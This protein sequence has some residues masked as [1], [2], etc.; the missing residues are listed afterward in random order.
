ME[1]VEKT[2]LETEEIEDGGTL[3]RKKL[4]EKQE[5]NSE[6]EEENDDSA[7]H[8]ETEKPAQDGEEDCS[9]HAVPEE[10]K[11]MTNIDG[12]ELSEGAPG[13]EDNSDPVLNM[14]VSVIE[15]DN[16]SE[17]LTETDNLSMVVNI[18]SSRRA[19]DVSNVSFPNFQL[20]DAGNAEGEDPD[21]D[22]DVD[23]ETPYQQ[24][25]DDYQPE[26]YDVDCDMPLELGP[27]TAGCLSMHESKL[28]YTDQIKERIDKRKHK[29]N[30]SEE[31][32][33]DSNKIKS[34]DVLPGNKKME[35]F[36][37]PL[38]GVHFHDRLHDNE[39]KIDG[40]S[41][42]DLADL[43]VK[44][45][46]PGH[47][48]KT[49]HSEAD[50]GSDFSAAAAVNANYNG[51][52][53]RNS[54]EVRNNIPDVSEVKSYDI[55]TVTDMKSVS[56]NV[57]PRMKKKSPGLARRIADKEIL[58]RDTSSSERETDL[59]V[60]LR[61]H[62][63]IKSNL[64][65]KT[66]GAEKHVEIETYDNVHSTNGAIHG[67]EGIKYLD[68]KDSKDPTNDIANEYDYVKFMRVQPG[69]S[70]V[71][72]RLAYSTSDKPNGSSRDSLTNI[73][74]DITPESQ[75]TPKRTP[76]QSHGNGTSFNPKLL[77]ENLTEIPLNS[78]SSQTE[79]K[80][81]SLSP[82]NT[83]C[84]SAEVESICS[85]SGLATNL[86][87]SVEDGLSSS[88]PSDSDDG[89]ADKDI[90]NPIDI[91]QSKQR[92]EAEQ[93]LK[94]TSTHGVSDSPQHPLPTV[95]SRS[96]ARSVAQLD[97]SSYTLDPL[98]MKQYE[99]DKPNDV[100]Q[101]L[102]DITVAIKKS[103]SMPLKAPYH[104]TNGGE[105]SESQEEPVWVMRDSYTK[106]VQRQEQMQKM[107]QEMEHLQE[108][109]LRSREEEKVFKLE[110]EED[111]LLQDKYSHG[112]EPKGYCS[113]DEY[114][115]HDR[116]IAKSFFQRKKKYASVPVED[117]SDT[118]YVRPDSYVKSSYSGGNVGNSHSL[119]SHGSLR[120]QKALGES[121][122]SRPQ[123][124][125][126]SPQSRKVSGRRIADHKRNS[127]SCDEESEGSQD[128]LE[129]AGPRGGAYTKH[130][131]RDTDTDEE[132]DQLLD[133][134]YTKDTHVDI[135]ELNDAP[136]TR[137]ANKLR[138]KEGE[139]ESLTVYDPD[140]PTV[141]IEGVLFRALYLGSTQLISEGTPSKAMRMMQ[142][143]EAVGRIKAPAGE[144]QP[145]TAVDL[146]VSTEKIMVLNTDLKEIMMDHALRTISYIADIDDIV[147]IMARRRLI[148]S[149]GDELLRKKKQAKILCHVFHSDEAQLIAQSIGQAF[150]VAY[151]EFLK[152]NGIDDPGLL[153]E[154]DYQ[155]V[156]NQQEIYGE[157]LAMFT[158]R[159]KQKEVIVPKLK[160]EILGIVIVESGWGSMVPTVVIA[161][162]AA[163]G[164][165]A[166]CG[167]LNIGD[168]IISINGVSL[169][170]L[171]LSSCQNYI[172]ALKS[173]TVVKLTVVSCPPVVEVR[174]KRPDVKYQLG[175]SVQNGV[176]CS[177]LRGGIAER[178]GVR[179]GHRIIE[180]NGE[181]VVAVP[182]EKIVTLL[183]NAIGELHMKTMPTAIYR[184]LT[185]QEIP[186]YI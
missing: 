91:L 24:D 160:S 4:K 25:G 135:P 64:P 66:N 181:S 175:F 95:T 55:D 131:E 36:Q 46:N 85:D 128:S 50:G 29:V 67:T 73:G 183:A 71:G 88:Q 163:N 162:M 141:L 125:Q 32:Q 13:G 115:E 15:T 3:K 7:S 182:H 154:M 96:A 105:S 156:L 107:R 90:E 54:A 146:F 75:M 19:S 168:Q 40:N 166:R 139:Q 56:S 153:K 10:D 79:G 37:Q 45:R 147:V 172:K 157:E 145:S 106:K 81:L 117:T 22:C 149:P 18:S 82:E 86:M 5:D 120:N 52:Q 102:H 136:A 39:I 113:D 31:I 93:F 179:V 133:K 123:T 48:N 180:I 170:G 158:N 47:Y 186:H 6:E 143:Q 124:F 89:P 137:Q 53:K 80:Y 62:R 16:T 28:D 33:G 42:S 155:D 99:Q 35:S 140:Q 97:L 60:S 74:G 43:G 165:A 27:D 164:P 21:V 151:L 78:D 109:E 69:S 142:A 130:E 26:D 8:M 77:E 61:M 101:A 100:S 57:L 118:T 152:A 51:I 87:P 14:S 138:A 92:A 129:S 167:Q 2:S 98:M 185:G 144:N 169:V 58:D 49:T 70:Y 1:Q 23:P 173:Q 171:P 161:N 63:N 150:Q 121:S 11:A 132:T 83:E 127:Y 148:T 119:S 76:H 112:Q 174:I 110:E 177:L 68:I 59:D 20:E 72:M 116:D 94:S 41:S 126:D 34:G 176:I 122:Y 12:V 111:K 84:D 159:D 184:L 9:D 103:K 30:T 114:E 134:Q 108:Q 178:G 44:R 38:E 104:K 17:D 65:S